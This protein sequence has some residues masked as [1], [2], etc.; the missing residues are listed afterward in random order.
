MK[1]EA[2]VEGVGLVGPGFTSWNEG[3]RLLDAS[4]YVPRPCVIPVPSALPANERRRAGKSVSLALAAGLEAASE[5]DWSTRDLVTIFASSSG[6]G[7]NCHQICEALASDDRAI[8]PTRFHNSVHNAPA[9]Y[10]GIATGA[11]RA[12][13]CVAAHDAS[14]G[15]GLLEAMTRIAVEPEQPVLLIAYD[16]PYP[17]PLHAVRTI[18]DCFAVALVLTRRSSSKAAPSM[19]LETCHARAEM[20]ADVALERLRAH[21]PAARCLPLLS[22]LARGSSG[23]TVI[24]YLDGLGLRVGVTA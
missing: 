1:L 9:G 3:R 15:A 12:A 23:E 14:F 24:E 7:E 18:A 2:R 16:A 10:W 17:E 19:T 6:D 8:S 11:M 21:I 13:D 5:A 22:L 20:L 4:A